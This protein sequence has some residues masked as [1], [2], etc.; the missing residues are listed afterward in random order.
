MEAGNAAQLS[1]PQWIGRTPH[2]PLTTGSKALVP[3]RNAFY[4]P[5]SGFESDE[6]W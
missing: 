6:H 4:L 5:P 3:D 1:V 2:E